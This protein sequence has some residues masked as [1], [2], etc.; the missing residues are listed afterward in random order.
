MDGIEK[1]WLDKLTALHAPLRINPT[2]SYYNSYYYLIDGKSAASDFTLKTIGEKRVAE[3]SDPYSLEE[4]SELF[5][6]LPLPDKEE[7]G[8]L[9]DPVKRAFSVLENLKEKHPGMTFQDYEM[10]GGLLRLE[11]T[12]G[13]ENAERTRSYLSQVAYFT[14]LADQ[15]PFL[16]NL[17]LAPTARD[18]VHEK[19]LKST[20]GETAKGEGVLLPKSFQDGGVLVG[21]RGYVSYPA[22]TLGALQEQRIPVHVSGF[23]DPGIM[24]VGNR[25]ILAPQS[26]VRAISISQGAY[27][28]DPSIASGIQVWF[29]DT[30]KADEIKAQ[31]QTAFQHAG[32]SSYWKTTSFREYEFAKDLLEQFQSDKLLF[33]LIGVIILVVAC[34]NII[35]LLVL[36]VND[37]KKEI[38][39][40]QSLGASPR[41]ISLIFA[42]CGS[43]LG[44]L[45]CL[46]GTAAAILTLQNIDSVVGFLSFLQGH[47]AFHAAFYGKTL[48]RDLSMDALIFVAVTTPVLSLLA[49]LVPALKASRLR[50]AEILRS[51]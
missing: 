3:R 21:D 24:A 30:A 46:I 38:G 48:P 22:S 25:C 44:I 14:T 47:E 17:L 20:F 10:S 15:N 36:L 33:T 37:K 35:S 34:C 16:K 19:F 27:T 8:A 11:L 31:I 23:Y 6:D 39:I 12:R 29:P 32:I 5:N 43:A 9:K 13:G 7:N 40:L 2:P 1:R 51:E 49:G 50:P 41:S 28:L 26:V 45:G 18:L 42:L 4:D